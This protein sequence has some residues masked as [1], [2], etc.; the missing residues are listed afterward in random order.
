MRQGC[1]LNGCVDGSHDRLTLLI[2]HHRQLPTAANQLH[3]FTSCGHPS[4]EAAAIASCLTQH[5]DCCAC[6]PTAAV[7]HLAAHLYMLLSTALGH[8]RML[9]SVLT[10]VEPDQVP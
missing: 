4:C 3:D 10:E 1:I 5:A 7:M 8:S 6:L 2:M 9:T